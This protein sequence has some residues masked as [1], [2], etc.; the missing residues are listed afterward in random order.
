MKITIR[1]KE[2]KMILVENQSRYLTE[3][4]KLKLLEQI[5]PGLDETA[6]TS[7]RLHVE[8]TIIAS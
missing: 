5:F 2:A 4:E 6:P 8:F 1:R 7:L 3:S